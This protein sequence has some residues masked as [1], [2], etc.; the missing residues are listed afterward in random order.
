MERCKHCGA[1]RADIELHDLMGS[2]FPCEEE[3]HDWEQVEIS[4]PD[5][6]A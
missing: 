6:S 2:D 4:S 3:T 1:S 5:E